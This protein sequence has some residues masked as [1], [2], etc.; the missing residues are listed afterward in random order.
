MKSFELNSKILFKGKFSRRDFISSNVVAMLEGSDKK[1]KDEYII[2]SA[3]YDHLGI[4]PAI[5]G[6][7]IYN[8]VMDN[9]MGVAGLIEIAKYLSNSDTKLKRSVIFLFVTGEEKGTLGSR[10]Y[11]DHPI[12]P[13][14]KTVANINIDGLA[15]ID[16]FKKIVGIGSEYSTFSEFMK[17]VCDSMNLELSTIPAE[18]RQFASF[19]LSDQIA[20]AEVGIPAILTMDYPDYNNIE[21]TD[22]INKLIDYSENIYHSPFDDLN[23]EINLDATFQHLEY[24]VKLT[25]LLANSEKTI[26]WNKGVP[27]NSARLRIKAE[28]R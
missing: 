17:E 25:E 24:I 14:Y 16:T 4:G 21:N 8:G 9:A 18:F 23:Q 15:F 5:N 1:L 2:L 26:E 19:N 10:Y 6:D 3:H 28:R 11:T 13:L 22:G 27:F 7:S 20:F 12:K